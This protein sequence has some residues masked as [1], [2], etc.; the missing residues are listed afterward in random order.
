MRPSKSISLASSDLNESRHVCAL[1]NSEEEE[2]RIL[3]P[4]IQNGLACG[5]KAIHIVNPNQD[6]EHV[7]RLASAGI[8]AATALRTGQLEVRANTETYLQDGRFDPDRMLEVFE[9]IAGGDPQHGYPLSRIVCRMD[10]AAD[11]RTHVDNLIE[12][13]ARVNDIWSRHDDV[14]ICTYHLTQFS[15]DAVIDILRTHPLVLLGGMLQR[16]PFYIPAEQFL[17]EFRAR[18]ARENVRHCGA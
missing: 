4:F 8:D 12:F 10:W 1:F 18:R 14:V 9:Q 7:E 15:G 2:Y 3:L 13:E 5:D 17:P 16:N 6:S 11:G